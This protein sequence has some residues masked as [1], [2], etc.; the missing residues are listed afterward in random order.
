[1][2][3]KVT[4]ICVTKDITC[5]KNLERLIIIIAIKDNN[6]I[7]N[8]MLIKWIFSPTANLNITSVIH[9]EKKPAISIN[10]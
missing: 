10:K 5:K 4:I 1:M 7:P 8:P 9:I 2:A 3:D 6:T